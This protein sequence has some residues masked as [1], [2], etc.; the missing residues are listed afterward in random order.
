MAT[1]LKTVDRLNASGFVPI[2]KRVLVLPDEA[3]VK[4]GSLY[5]PDSKVE[6]DKFAQCDATLVAV[7]ETAWAEATSEAARHGLEFTAP[8]AGDR[9]LIQKYGGTML[10]GRDGKQYRIM[11]DDDILARLKD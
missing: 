1:Q 10:E 2:D 4:I 11:N 9:V 3:P 5:M 7:G 8:A 6:R